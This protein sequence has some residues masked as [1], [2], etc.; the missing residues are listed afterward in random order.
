MIDDVFT[1]LDPVWQ[2]NNA[3]FGV[4]IHP[5]G[6]LAGLNWNSSAY[7][8]TNPVPVSVGVPYVVEWWIAAGVM[9][10]RIN[11]G[12]VQTKTTPNLFDV[13]SPLSI[14]QTLAKI[15]LCELVTFNVIPSQTQ[16]DALVNNMRQYIGA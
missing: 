11:S 13:S 8:S 5:P 7:D 10:F 16:R 2:D 1:D 12:T 9:S 15:K 14:A 4:A 3:D 6:Y